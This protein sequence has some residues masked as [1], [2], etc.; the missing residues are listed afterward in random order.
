MFYGLGAETERDLI[1]RFF[2]LTEVTFV[3]KSRGDITTTFALLYFEEHWS[4]L[5][6]V[7]VAENKS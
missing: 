4:T 3:Q 7:N 5:T 1:L 2:P 6:A